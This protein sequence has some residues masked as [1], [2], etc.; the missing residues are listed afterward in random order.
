[1]WKMRNLTL[2]GK[3]VILKQQ[4]YQELFS[5]HNNCPKTCCEQTLKK[6]EGLFYGITLLLR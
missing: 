1:M 5:N 4:R 3:I 2:E 6:Y